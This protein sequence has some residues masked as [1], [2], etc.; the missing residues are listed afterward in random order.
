MKKTTGESER[1]RSDVERYSEV[2]KDCIGRLQKIR[3]KSKSDSF[4][5]DMRDVLGTVR[6]AMYYKYSYQGAP[7]NSLDWIAKNF[8]F[9][10]DADKGAEM[11]DEMLEN[12]E[13]KCE[14]APKCKGWKYVQIY[15]EGCEPKMLTGEL[16]EDDDIIF[17]SG[18]TVKMCGSS[19]ITRYNDGDEEGAKRR[20]IEFAKADEDSK[21]EESVRIKGLYDAL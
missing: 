9:Y 3:L 8:D 13:R 2:L 7:C 20:L 15:W 1:M 5:Q 4:R 21:I 18:D 11:M 17:E 16:D 12:Y 14:A 10:G 19:Y 6:M